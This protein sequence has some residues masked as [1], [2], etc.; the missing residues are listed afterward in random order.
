MVLG[1]ITSI[2]SVRIMLA[3][4][5]ALDLVTDLALLKEMDYV[6]NVSLIHLFYCSYSTLLLK[7]S[8]SVIF[9]G[10]S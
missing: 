10:S 6:G 3:P 4:L 2:V 1:F 5:L 9:V 8:L 7:W